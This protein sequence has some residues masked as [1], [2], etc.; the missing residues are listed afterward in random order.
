MYS[1]QRTI[2]VKPSA[3]LRKSGPSSPTLKSVTLYLY[4]YF[5][6]ICIFAVLHLQTTANPSYVWTYLAVKV[7]LI[8]I[9]WKSIQHILCDLADNPTYRQ[10][11]ENMTCLVEVKVN[12]HWH[13][14]QQ[15]ISVFLL[16]IMLSSTK[17]WTLWMTAEKQKKKKKKTSVLWIIWTKNGENDCRSSSSTFSVH[18]IFLICSSVAVMSLQT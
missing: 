14:E 2:Q 15:S 16:L 12:S 7:I 4:L 9:L 3:P 18:A 11:G 10:T 6:I 8:L 17:S 5:F 13:L 1:D